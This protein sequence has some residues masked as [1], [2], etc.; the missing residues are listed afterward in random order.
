MIWQSQPEVDNKG[1]IGESLLRTAFVGEFVPLGC[2]AL[3]FPL[4]VLLV[5]VQVDP[6]Q[7]NSQIHFVGMIRPCPE[8]ELTSLTVKRVE[9][10]VNLAHRRKH[11]FDCAKINS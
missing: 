9:G 8:L 11:T 10:D 6:G 1:N 7:G 5:V 2:R 4:S 3:D